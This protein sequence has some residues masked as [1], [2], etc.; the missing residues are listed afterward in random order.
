MN[1]QTPSFSDAF[2]K[3]A[4]AAFAFL[5][6]EWQFEFCGIS[7]DEHLDPRDRRTIV[8]YRNARVFLDVVLTH[9]ELG[10]FVYLWEAPDSTSN[11]ACWETRPLRTENFDH[12]LQSRFGDTI[13]PVFSNLTKPL[14]L[15]EVYN[16]HTV[17]YAK[18]MT[19]RLHE[20][21]AA[22]AARFQQ[23]GRDALEEFSLLSR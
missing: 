6:K 13:A 21:I 1:A 11:G 15:T 14:Y 20:A 16:E 19:T 18:L 17:K 5:T 2:C 10:L 23:F 8:R 4:I 12:F 22:T 9:I 7:S 3:T